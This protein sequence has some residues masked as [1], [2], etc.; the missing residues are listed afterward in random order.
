[1]STDS[2]ALDPE[3]EN[4]VCANGDKASEE[5]MCASVLPSS[6]THL[7]GLQS[8]LKITSQAA[9]TL[10]YR[11]CSVTVRHNKGNDFIKE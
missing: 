5:M 9:F 8:R 3:S 10:V 7:R 6:Y 2:G 1:M 11:D 4:G